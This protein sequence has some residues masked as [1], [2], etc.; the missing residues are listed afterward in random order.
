M[1]LEEEPEPS[2]E[3]LELFDAIAEQL[4]Q[5]STCS[6]G[7]ATGAALMHL[8][9][10][11]EP[12]KEE[13]ELF[14][15][16]AEQLSQG[17]TCS[18]GPAKEAV[19]S[20]EFH[21]NESD[22][23]ESQR[24]QGRREARGEVDCANKASN[25]QHPQLRIETVCG[26]AYSEVELQRREK[27]ALQDELSGFEGICFWCGGTRHF[28]NTCP[29]LAHRLQPPSPITAAVAVAA[30]GG[31]TSA[32][33]TEGLADER[34][35]SDR[36]PHPRTAGPPG[37]MGPGRAAGTKRRLE[38]EH[39]LVHPR[40]DAAEQED[41]SKYALQVGT[42]PLSKRLRSARE[43]AVPQVM[44]TGFAGAHYPAMG[45]ARAAGADDQQGAV[46]V[47]HAQQREERLHQPQ[48]S[49]R[50]D[51]ASPTS[52]PARNRSQRAAQCLVC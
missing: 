25:V 26:G 39:A 28:V 31:D 40:A 16:I 8:E 50:V 34:R 41:V 27:L 36:P 29:A 4:S 14:D 6:T 46:G 22:I 2:K 47:L 20:S 7:P 35:N 1:H 13:L 21:V 5:G 17:S 12:S 43:R 32:S 30:V 33:R 24:T 38:E 3:E 10:E 37:G 23:D 51:P 49:T 15:A 44:E 45:A 52:H 11:P 18:T 9:E 19:H 42:D 48:P